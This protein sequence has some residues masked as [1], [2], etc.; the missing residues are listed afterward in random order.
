MTAEIAEGAMVGIMR[1][2][3]FTPWL[4]LGLLRLVT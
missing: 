1:T 4:R 2:L 3:S